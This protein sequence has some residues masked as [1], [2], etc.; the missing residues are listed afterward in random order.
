[1]GN[2][3]ICETLRSYLG[4][5]LRIVELENVVKRQCR[6]QIFEPGAYVSSEDISEVGRESGKN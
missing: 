4:H 6:G 5:G 3:Q 2:S 1:M